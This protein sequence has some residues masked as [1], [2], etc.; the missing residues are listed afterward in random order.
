MPG[1]FNPAKKEPQVQFLCP[2]AGGV[3]RTAAG[4]AFVPVTPVRH[5]SKP[6]STHHVLQPIDKARKRR[7]LKK[8]RRDIF[9]KPAPAPIVPYRHKLPAPAR[10]VTYE[11][12]QK[13]AEQQLQQEHRAK[14]QH[15][16]QELVKRLSQ[17][18]QP[19][20]GV[21]RTAVSAARCLPLCCG[22]WV[23]CNIR[24]SIYSSE[25]DSSCSVG[26]VCS[27]AVLGDC[28]SKC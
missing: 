13:R 23:P 3:L 15:I 21:P 28:E 24:Y 7:F 22:A 14:Q 27:P 6:R 25:N 19:V 1:R 2:S 8:V 5:Y 18:K 26:S 9:Q 11:Q 17:A 4:D 10:V 12:L 20:S 16:R